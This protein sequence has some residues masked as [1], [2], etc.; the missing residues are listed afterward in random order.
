M[1]WLKP[2]NQRSLVRTLLLHRPV[3]KGGK[4]KR[5]SKMFFVD[6]EKKHF[7]V[8]FFFGISE[9]E[10]PGTWELV[11]VYPVRMGVK[12]IRA[13]EVVRNSSSKFEVQI[14]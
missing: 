12:E 14:I 3:H 6:I 11:L 13:V 4:A 9:L 1:Q 10:V 5:V 7:F 2:G 8:Y